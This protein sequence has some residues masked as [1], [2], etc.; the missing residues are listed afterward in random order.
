MKSKI[1]N[2][3]FLICITF[4]TFSQDIA[5]TQY[6]SNP[7]YLNPALAGNEGCARGIINQRLQWTQLPANLSALNVGFDIYSNKLNGGVGAYYQSESRG[8]G[9]LKRKSINCIYAYHFNIKDKINFSLGLQGSLVI[10]TLDW[11]KIIF[12]DR[13]DPVRGFIYQSE[14]IPDMNMIIYPDF[15]FG[16]TAN[17]RSYYAGLAIHHI[18]EPNESFLNVQEVALTRKYTIYSGK[19]IEIKRSSDKNFEILPG[20][21]F[22]KQG[23]TNQWVVG[24]TVKYQSL[25]MGLRYRNKDAVIFLA[26]FQKGIISIGYSFDATISNMAKSSNRILGSHELTLIFRNFLCKTRKE[27]FEN[28]LSPYL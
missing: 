24:S 9:I 1:Y 3:L 5:F 15:S 11:S 14:E 26:G 10:K 2:F 23:Q 16:I 17:T 27:K 13:I 6:H 19:K 22:M 28:Y 18:A 21:L 25:L 20:F 4:P 8:S 12:G 7:L